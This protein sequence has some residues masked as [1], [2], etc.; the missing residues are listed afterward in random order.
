MT[1]EALF[2]ELEAV[3]EAFNRAV[4]SNDVAAIASCTSEDWTL[5]TPEAGP[6]S[7]DRFLY[8]VSQGILSH[9]SMTKDISRVRVY[10][11]V[12]VVTGRGRNTGT[13]HGA[14]ISA[15]EWVTDVYVKIGNRWICT[16]THLTPVVVPSD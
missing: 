7:R 8:V 6:V 4:I 2:K 5:V 3:E 12:A 14:A 16:L 11:D 1:D 10:G 9:D 15:D 13:F